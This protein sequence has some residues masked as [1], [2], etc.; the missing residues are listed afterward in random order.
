MTKL[1]TEIIEILESIKTIWKEI[2]SELFQRLHTVDSNEEF[3]EIALELVSFFRD[4]YTELYLELDLQ[5]RKFITLST[6]SEIIL[7]E[8]QSAKVLRHQVLETYLIGDE[9][10]WDL[11]AA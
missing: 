4:K 11:M 3:N 5:V 7:N 9:L 8:S 6:I 10:P 1:R 2:K